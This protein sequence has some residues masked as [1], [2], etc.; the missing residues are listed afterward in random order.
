MR[1]KGELIKPSPN[2]FRFADAVYKSLGTNF[3]PFSTPQNSGTIKVKL[4]NVSFSV[5][6]L[7]DLDVIDLHSLTTWT[8]NNTLVKRIVK[9]G[10]QKDLWSVKG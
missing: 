4:E 6:A 10:M 5:P 2:S 7:L 8:V 1:R 9:G 3:L